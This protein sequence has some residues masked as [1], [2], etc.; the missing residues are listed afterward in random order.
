ML[1]FALVSKKFDVSNP[2]PTDLA[3]MAVC[4]ESVR[5]PRSLMKRSNPTT[6]RNVPSVPKTAA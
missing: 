6:P 3:N 5:L 2:F 4:T 1:Q